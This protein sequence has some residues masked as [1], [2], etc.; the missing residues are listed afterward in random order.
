MKVINL[1]RRAMHNSDSSAQSL[2]E[3][4]AGIANQSDLLN[5]RFEAVIAGLITPERGRAPP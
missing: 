2:T 4:L 1:L 3:I 5:R